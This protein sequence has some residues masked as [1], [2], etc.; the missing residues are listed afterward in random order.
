MPLRTQLSLLP[1]GFCR[2]TRSASSAK[3][4]N[5]TGG[6]SSRIAKPF[7]RGVSSDCGDFTCPVVKP[8]E[9]EE[10]EPPR[11]EFAVYFWICW[12][13]LFR[14]KKI[15]SFFG[16]PFVKFLWNKIA[17]IYIYLYIHIYI[18]IYLNIYIYMYINIYI[19]KEYIYLIYIKN[20]QPKLGIFPKSNQ[21]LTF[22][23]G[24]TVGESCG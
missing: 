24:Q 13:Q 14:F 7:L 5:P 1:M 23:S 22:E 17:Y 9:K 2:L 18:Y 11:D 6:I 21:T 10:L 15:S 3:L 12:F 8:P 20:Y 19:I 4:E 16:Y